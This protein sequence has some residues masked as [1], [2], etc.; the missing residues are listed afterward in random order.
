VRGAPRGLGAAAP[1]LKGPRQ[2]AR[3]RRPL[4]RPPTQP[5]PTTPRS[6]EETRFLNKIEAQKGYEAGSSIGLVED[7]HEA[8]GLGGGL[9]AGGGGGGG[10]GGGGFTQ[11]QLLKVS[12]AESL[13]EERDTEIRKVGAGGGAGGGA[14]RGPHGSPVTGRA[15]P[16]DGPTPGGWRPGGSPS[17]LRGNGGAK[18]R[19]TQRAN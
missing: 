5:P 13:V 1:Q 12:Q 18:W 15:W 19:K 9:R 3:P 11:A 7:E 14:G 2:W 4:P 10:P 17:V 16:P 8:G 6:K